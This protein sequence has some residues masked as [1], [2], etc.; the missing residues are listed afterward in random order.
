MFKKILSLLIVFFIV[1]SLAAT[2]YADQTVFGPKD[3]EIKRWYFHFSSHRFKVDDPAEGVLTIIKNTPG[4]KIRGGFCFVN[5]KYIRLRNFL[6]G[7]GDIFEKEVKLRSRNR[8][9]IYLRGS[10][11]AS[12][13]VEIRK[14]GAYP[15]PEVSLTADPTTADPTRSSGDQSWTLSWTSN[16]AHTCA[17]EPG[18]GKVDLEGSRTVSPTETT[19]YT[20]TATGPGGTATANATVTLA[21]TAPVANDQTVTLNEDQ[22]TSIALTASDANGDALTYQVVTGPTHGTLT[23]QAPNLTYTAFSEL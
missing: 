6:K 12:V 18:I 5:G 20:I 3:L 1:S 7:K 14:K 21:N 17:I 19:T 2:V 16:L 13:R 10:R 9:Y 22:A 23:G 15:P 8:V 11:R 4:K